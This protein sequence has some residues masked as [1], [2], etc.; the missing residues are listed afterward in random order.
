MAW[1]I[2]VAEPGDMPPST[3]TAVSLRLVPQNPRGIVQQSARGFW[4]S[5]TQLQAAVMAIPA[6]P[7]SLNRVGHSPSRE[8]PTYH[9][10]YHRKSPCTCIIVTEH[11]NLIYL[12][13]QQDVYESGIATFEVASGDENRVPLANRCRTTVQERH[14]AVGREADAHEVLPVLLRVSQEFDWEGK[15][16]RIGARVYD[17]LSDVAGG[18]VDLPKVV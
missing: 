11:C 14:G 5:R 4:Y 10:R 3:H 15:L 9:H 17:G 16:N 13:G 18:K 1:R 12:F 6:E 8:F 2:T 7:S